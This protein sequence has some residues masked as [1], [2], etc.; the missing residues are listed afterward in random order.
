V[1][2]RSGEVMANLGTFHFQMVHEVGSTA[3]LPG[4]NVE[5]TF[6]D[7]QPPDRLYAEFS[8]LFGNIPI[9]AKLIA[10]GDANY[11]TNPLNGEWQKIDANVSPIQFFNP[12]EGISSVLDEV[13]GAVFVE[14]GRDQYKLTGKVPASSLEALLGATVKEGVVDLEVEIDAHTLH[15]TL[16][17]FTGQVAPSD[18]PDTVR[19]VTLSKFDEPVNIEAPDIP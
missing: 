16:A 5:D 18:G 10:I 1:L 12:K 15:L 3:F 8:G 9:H 4:L 14:S 7:V 19:V 6:G 17:R 11:M 13:T 2:A